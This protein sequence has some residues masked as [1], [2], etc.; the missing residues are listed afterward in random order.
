MGKW[1]MDLDRCSLYL[2]F[3]TAEEPTREMNLIQQEM[4]FRERE[5]KSKIKDD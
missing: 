5:M 4:R 1:K 3:L 2:I